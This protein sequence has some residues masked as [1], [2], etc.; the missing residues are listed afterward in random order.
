MSSTDTIRT[1]CKIGISTDLYFPPIHDLYQSMT[2]TGD[3]SSNSHIPEY[4]EIFRGR[5]VDLKQAREETIPEEIPLRYHGD[6]LWY[7]QPVFRAQPATRQEIVRANAHM[8]A[9]G[10]SWMIHECAHKSFGGRTFGTY[11]PPLLSRESANLIRENTLWLMEQMEG[12]QLI[13]EIPPFPF[14]LAGSMHPGDFFNTIVKGTDLGLGLDIGHVLT[15]IEAAGI[16]P[17]PETI[18]EWISDHLPLDHVME[19]HMGGLSTFR[20]KSASLYQDDHTAPIPPILW[21]SLEAVCR[22]CPMVNL[23]GMALEVDNKEIGVIIPE[24]RKFHDLI[25]SSRI[26]SVP[27]YLSP[28]ERQEHMPAG[29]RSQDMILL[30][31][32]YQ[33]LSEYLSGQNPDPPVFI[34][35]YP[36]IYRNSVYPHE[37]WSFGGAIEAVFPDTMKIIRPLLKD[38]QRS[39][40]QYFHRDLLSEIFPFDFLVFKSMKF[41][42]WIGEIA[43]ALPEE[44]QEAAIKTSEKEL[45]RILSDQLFINGDD[46]S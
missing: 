18:H 33:T 29:E 7:T 32:D 34:R 27:F 28:R 42:E 41:R 8:D 19:V 17:Q 15:L 43:G 45:N 4:I 1:T 30:E 44:M 37:V 3:R 31:K 39:F 35:G 26:S 36:N 10:S 5:T 14:F 6:A 23:K 12:R 25:E 24:F 16:K 21:E 40:V 38:P 11:L 2:D 22:F 13:V 9:L 20:E 46:L